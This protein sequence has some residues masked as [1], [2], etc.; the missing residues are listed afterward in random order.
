MWICSLPEWWVRVA[1]SLQWLGYWHDDWGIVIRIHK[2]QTIFFSLN[3]P[4]WLWG[5]TSLLLGNKC[6]FPLDNRPWSNADHSHL[7]GVELNLGFLT[8]IHG[9]GTTLLLYQTSNW[10]LR[11]SYVSNDKLNEP[12]K[13]IISSKPRKRN[14]TFFRFIN[15]L[16]RMNKFWFCSQ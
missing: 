14:H 7:L 1:Q 15:N 16:Y 8:Y 2:G 5:P 3:W 12:V 11:F 4:E 10:T 9:M 6:P 13:L